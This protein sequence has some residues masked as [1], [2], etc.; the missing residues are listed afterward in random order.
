MYKP[1]IIIKPQ[2]WIRQLVIRVNVNKISVN[3]IILGEKQAFSQITDTCI[4]IL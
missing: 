3:S 2:L 1:S 4:L